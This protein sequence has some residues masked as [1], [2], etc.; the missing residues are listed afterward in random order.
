M[1]ASEQTSCLL[2]FTVNESQIPQQVS[3]ANY[4]DLIVDT[5][6][7]G[8]HGSAKLKMIRGPKRDAPSS[9]T[10]FKQFSL[11][12][13]DRVIDLDVYVFF[14]TER[15]VCEVFSHLII[16]DITDFSEGFVMRAFVGC[17]PFFPSA[18]LFLQ[19]RAELRSNAPLAVM[20]ILLH[21]EEIGQPF[22]AFGL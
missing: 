13:Y 2:E 3:L 15:P 1:S 18:A 11:K 7:F 20:V 5:H 6:A 17:H 21:S 16:D 12:D 22:A 14:R 9:F 19:K 4:I 10:R 8:C